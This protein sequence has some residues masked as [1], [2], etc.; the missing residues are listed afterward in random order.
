VA[1]GPA[2]HRDYHETVTRALGLDPVWDDKPAWTGQILA[3]RARGW[4]WRPT[5]DLGA[6]LAEVESGLR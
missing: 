2:T 5:V 6:A 1:A 3:D 4:G